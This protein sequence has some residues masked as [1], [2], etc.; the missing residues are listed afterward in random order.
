MNM[1]R[2]LRLLQTRRGIS[3]LTTNSFQNKTAIVTGGNR[4]IGLA[5]ATHFAQ[6]GAKVYTVSRSGGGNVGIE[7]KCDVGK[8]EEV[9]ALCKEM[10]EKE[11]NIDFLVNCAGIS[12][13]ALLL[14]TKATSVQQLINTNLLGTMFLCRGLLKPML[15][16]RQGCIINL[17]SVAAL[18]GIS[19]LSVYSAAKS[20]VIGFSKSL[21]K[22]LLSRNIRV[23]VI[24]PGYI[25]TD[26]THYIRGEKR[27]DITSRTL[28]QTFG[29][30]EDVA[31]AALY[32]AEAKY[33]TGQVLVVDGG[34]T[35][36]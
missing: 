18:R 19:G 35:L 24:A 33:V 28:A 14:H 20:G 26:M 8:V 1:T 36:S 21:A 30:P 17:S 10:V 15:R 31:L 23:N 29:S 25:E 7:L 34:L 5:I 2:Y 16:Q 13:D 9:D 32:L 11:K 27:A 6:R 12:E 3:S 4:G 22:E